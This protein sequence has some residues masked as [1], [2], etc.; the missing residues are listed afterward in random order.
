MKSKAL[1]VRKINI[2][3]IERDTGIGKDTLRVWERRYGFPTPSRDEYGERI[4]PTAQFEKLRLIKRLIDAGHRPGKVVPQSLGQLRQSIENLDA[5]Q[6][7][8]VSNGGGNPVLNELLALVKTHNTE[9]LRIA[10]GQQLIS[11]G[12][13]Q[14]ISE[15]VA[16]LTQLV[17]EA[18]LKGE[19]EVFEEHLFTEVIYGVLRHAIAS[20]PLPDGRERNPRVLLTTFPNEPHGLGL[21]MAEALLTLQSSRCISLGT[22]TPITEIVSAAVA[23]KADIVALSFT[24]VVKPRLV[25]AG[26]SELRRLLPRHIQIWAGGANSA[27]RHKRGIQADA[28]L[29]LDA[30]ALE[31]SEWRAAHA[32]QVVAK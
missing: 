3:A 11:L 19:L 24:S 16:P 28:V 29:T 6:Q 31:V 22:Q 23:K 9:Q 25:K 26:L 27:L 13:G 7:L 5:A 15:L 20:I 14:F 17:G 10:L 2:A 12:L 1:Q 8:F 4:Y 18:W 30:V 32:S 21:L